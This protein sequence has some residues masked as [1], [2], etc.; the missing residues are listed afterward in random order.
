MLLTL[1]NLNIW[2]LENTF[3][4]FITNVRSDPKF[5]NCHDLGDLAIKMIWIEVSKNFGLIYRL[6]E[7]TLINNI[8]SSYS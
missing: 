7:L 4:S 8:L 3:V 2:G 1:I 5:A 6:V